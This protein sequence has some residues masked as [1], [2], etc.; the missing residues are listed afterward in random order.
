MQPVTLREVL[1]HASTLSSDEYLRWCDAIT[2]DRLNK[3][4]RSDI[5]C[6]IFTWG[7][8]ISD[9]NPIFQDGRTSVDV[10]GGAYI[11]LYV[12]LAI[13]RKTKNVLVAN[14]PMMIG[15]NMHDDHLIPD[16]I[17]KALFNPLVDIYKDTERYKNRLIK[18]AL[19][20]SRCEC[21]KRKYY[22]FTKGCVCERILE[23]HD[24]MTW[25][26]LEERY[27]DL[28]VILNYL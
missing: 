9:H 16:Y 1:Y 18:Y 26:Q 4:N 13:N 5:K 20:G 25:Q 2:M 7:T 28:P 6:E 12:V 8:L 21:G 11:H 14:Y 22:D 3:S 19:R 15:Y 24:G 10:E 17:S 27:P 23:E